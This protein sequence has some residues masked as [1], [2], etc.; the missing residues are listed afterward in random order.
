MHRRTQ[1]GMGICM[2]I[3]VKLACDPSPDPMQGY[4]HEHI[5][6]VRYMVQL[7]PDTY[8]DT[9]YGA[10]TPFRVAEI[11]TID[12]HDNMLPVSTLPALPAT[13]ATAGP[14]PPPR[15]P[16]VSPAAGS[17][18]PKPH[19]AMTVVFVDRAGNR[20]TFTARATKSFASFFKAYCEHKNIPKTVI[21]SGPNGPVEQDGAQFTYKGRKLLP[22]DTPRAVGMTDGDHVDV[23]VLDVPMGNKVVQVGAELW[24]ACRSAAMFITVRRLGK[25]VQANVRQCAVCS[26]VHEVCMCYASTRPGV[27]V[28]VCVHA[29][30]CMQV[31][32]EPGAAKSEE[33]KSVSVGPINEQGTAAGSTVG[34]LCTHTHTH[35]HMCTHTDVHMHSRWQPASQPAG[36]D[37]VLVYVCMQAAGDKRAGQGAPSAAA[38]A[39]KRV[40]RE[41]E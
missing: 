20:V 10:T 15:V 13:P 30:V 35:T 32:A 40:K 23:V 6:E 41:K 31:L 21:T 33:D 9:S 37:G 3:E 38:A 4:K 14:K 29:C 18:A 1:Q 24:R 26:A 36:Y 34:A 22:T 27:Y 25:H 11:T 7:H 5:Q 19:A 16:P 17:S 8:I 2:N 28:H 39:V 12:I